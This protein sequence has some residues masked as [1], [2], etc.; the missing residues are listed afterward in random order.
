M[1]AWS[2]I[3]LG[4]LAIGVFRSYKC[5]S[6]GCTFHSGFLS[7]VTSDLRKA[8]VDEQLRT[9]DIGGVVGRKENNRPRDLVGR[10]EP[11]ERTSGRNGLAA[12]LARRSRGEQVS[13]SR[14][15]DRSRAHRVD[16]N[17]AR[18]QIGRPSA[19]K[20][21]HGGFGGGIDAVGRQACCR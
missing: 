11:A 7:V 13:E 8:T 14:R 9:G 19:G 4:R 18:F 6:P 15:I 2:L 10:A 12:L 17:T 21:P 20:G 16:A 1:N 5:N 3:T